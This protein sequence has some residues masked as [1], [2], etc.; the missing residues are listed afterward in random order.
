MMD[1]IRACI[2][3]SAG[4]AIHQLSP[5]K[6]KSAPPEVIEAVKGASICARL[7][8]RSSSERRPLKAKMTDLRWCAEGKAAAKKC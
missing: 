4:F 5:L 1:R 7:S 2:G 3:I 8:E 6:G